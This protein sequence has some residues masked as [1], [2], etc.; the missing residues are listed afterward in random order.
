MLFLSPYFS[1]T[2][3]SCCKQIIFILNS[4]IGK[5]SKRV[6]S[7]I[8]YFT[9]G[10]FLGIGLFILLPQGKERMES[11]AHESIKDPKWQEMP[12]CFFISFLSYSFMLFV[13]KVCFSFTSLIPII[14]DI[15]PHGHAHQH[16]EIDSGHLP[17][18]HIH[19]DQ[20]DNDENEEV[21]KN[22]VSTKGKFASFMQ[23]RN[24]KY[25]Q[26]KSI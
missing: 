20:A 9:G 23:I 14:N 1:D 26:F 16:N 15:E 19:E 3:L 6:L 18:E 4:K 13:E 8:N 5:C 22:V 11:W 25:F 7:F 10:L 12:Y 24:C 17:S 2:I 21:F